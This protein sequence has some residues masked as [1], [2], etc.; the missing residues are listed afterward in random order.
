MKYIYSLLF[1]F[2]I[3][4]C[5]EPFDYEVENYQRVLVVDA[6]ITDAANADTVKISYTAP[7]DGSSPEPAE[8]A[9]VYIRNGADLRIDFKELEQ[10][11]YTSPEGFRALPGEVYRLFITTEEGD[12]YRSD[13]EKLVPSPP[14][15]SIYGRYEEV[16]SQDNKVI[17]G[18]Q[19][20]LDTGVET[21][22]AAFFRYE[23]EETYRVITPLRSFLTFN[24]SNKTFEERTENISTCYA[25][26][27]SRELLLA[28]SVL[29]RDQRLSES[30][31]RFVNQEP[32]ILRSRYALLVRQYAISQKAYDYYK[33]LQE[34]IRT[35]GSLFDQQQGA[36]IGNIRSVSNPAQPALGYFEVAGISEK[37][38]FFNPRNFEPPFARPDFR[39]DCR[40]GPR[41]LE[42]SDIDLIAETLA[43]GGLNVVTIDTMTG[44]V[45]IIS[46]S[47]TDCTGYASNKKPDFWID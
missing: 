6:V 14:I 22:E 42:L 16:L 46:E 20:F 1:L 5:I 36:I 23:W 33:K 17:Q 15:D 34:S 8:N 40:S 41:A 37:R 38:T 13:A 10:G 44:M 24:A 43:R 26:N 47:C 18:I 31:I 21:G 9:T 28:T 11:I 32:D 19:F 12:T 3:S 29:N 35:G 39:F 30:P 27:T 4:A 2:S 7:I 25:T 45:F